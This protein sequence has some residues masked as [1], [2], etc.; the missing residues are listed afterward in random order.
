MANTYPKISEVLEIINKSQ[1]IHFKQD[2]QEFELLPSSNKTNNVIYYG[3]NTD[4]YL[5]LYNWGTKE[6]LR[7][8]FLQN[9]YAK[10]GYYIEAL[11]MLEN[12]VIPLFNQQQSQIIKGFKKERYRL[13]YQSLFSVFHEMGHCVFYSHEDVRTSYF[14][15]VKKEYNDSY[16]TADNHEIVESRYKDNAPWYLRG[17]SKLFGL[18]LKEY[19]EGMLNKK[20]KVLENSIE[21]MACD[22]YAADMFFKWNNQEKCFSDKDMQLI[23]TSII[24]MQSCIA[25]HDYMRNYV[26]N[27]EKIP[28]NRIPFI[29]FRRSL[30]VGRLFDILNNKY[31]KYLEDF[32][33]DC[34]KN[35][36]N[37]HYYFLLSQSLRSSANFLE[38]GPNIDYELVDKENY[39]IHVKGFVE[40]ALKDTIT[41]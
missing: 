7:K 21:E 2:V 31:D 4:V 33:R 9:E 14:D 40:S 16:G 36:A 12:D 22:Y 6:L 15:G 34:K 35:N 13:F 38:Q 1:S 26:G 37:L 30:L 11:S 32:E 10:S 3:D 19:V 39:I 24:D 41:I 8:F 18:N 27:N 29:A 17:L 25:E 5:I 23:C 28:K 20:E